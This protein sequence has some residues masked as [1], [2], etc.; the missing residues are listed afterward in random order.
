MWSPV[1][2]NCGTGA[3]G[4]KK[5]NNCA[6]GSFSSKED[7]AEQLGLPAP[8]NVDAYWT[9]VG[10]HK[11]SAAELR[12]GVAGELEKRGFIKRYSGRTSIGDT[13]DYEHPTDGHMVFVS[14]RPIVDPYSTTYKATKEGP[15]D[16]RYKILYVPPILQ[17]GVRMA[18]NVITDIEGRIERLI[19]AG[20]RDRDLGAETRY[21]RGYWREIIYGVQE[22]KRRIASNDPKQALKAVDK[23]LNKVPRGKAAGEIKTSM[24]VLRDWIMDQPGVGNQ[25]R[26]V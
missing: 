20:R 22:A 4:F 2:N 6:R 14:A 1:D 9:H 18:Q 11:G 10:E 25:W 12:A 15:Y 8:N 13:I 7:M 23:V 19:D 21:R 24:S 3:G 5:G 17:E 16:L 26:A